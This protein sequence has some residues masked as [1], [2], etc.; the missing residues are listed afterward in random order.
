[1]SGI[2]RIAAE[3]RR[4]LGAEG[5]TVAHD[6]CHDR[7]QL[8]WAAVCYAAPDLVF[9]ERRYANRIVFVD[10]WP[11]DDGDK[12]PHRGNIVLPN[13]GVSVQERMRQLEKAGALIAAEIDRLERIERQERRHG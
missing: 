12:R 11:W 9:R 7:G 4:Q 10:T 6:D 8:A 13:L 1:V 3:R 2:E 5:W